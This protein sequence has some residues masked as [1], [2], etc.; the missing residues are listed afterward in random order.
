MR[1]TRKCKLRG[2]SAVILAQPAFG[3]ETIPLTVAD[4]ERLDPYYIRRVRTTLGIQHPHWPRI[5]NKHV[6]TYYMMGYLK[7]N[8]HA[9]AS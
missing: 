9:Y 5:I 4:Y 3:L 7:T 2:Y 6:Y 8:Q 1:V